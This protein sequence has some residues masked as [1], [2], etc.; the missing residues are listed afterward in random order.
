M[1]AHSAWDGLAGCAT[2]NIH[3]GAETPRLPTAA[4]LGGD[5][6]H[7]WLL[8]HQEGLAS[9]L[10]LVVSLRD[11]IWGNIVTI[12]NEKLLML[13]TTKTKQYFDI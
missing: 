2:S 10:G 7:L 9:E 8:S 13:I 5:R 12:F 6:G 1:A 11:G 4:A 3:Q